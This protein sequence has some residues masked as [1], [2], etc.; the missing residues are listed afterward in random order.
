MRAQYN[1]KT[2][3]TPAQEGSVEKP[4]AHD[5]E[6]TRFLESR[7]LTVLRIRNEE[8]DDLNQATLRIERA[9]KAIPSRQP[10]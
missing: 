5:T 9:A 8:L 4:I 1:G 10:A 2:L 6:R 7:G 3:R